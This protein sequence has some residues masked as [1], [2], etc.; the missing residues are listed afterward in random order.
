MTL[1]LQRPRQRILRRQ[2]KLEGIL[3]DGNGNVYA[4]KSRYYVRLA[5]QTDAT[6]NVT[7]GE[8]LPIRYAAASSVPPLEG[9][10]V[11]IAVDYDDELSI[12]RVKPDWFER[13]NIDSRTFNQAEP[14]DRFV[15]LMNIITK[16]TRPVGSA[17]SVDST[18]LTIRE[19]PFWVDDFLNWFIYAGT[20]RAA[21]KPDLASYIPAADTHRLIC[22]FFDTFQQDYFIAGSTAQALTTAIDSTDFDECFAQLEHNEYSPLLALKLANAQTAITINDMVEDLRQWLNAPKVYGN[23]NPLP[24]DKGMILRSTHQLIV[25]NYAFEGEAIIEGDLVIL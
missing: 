3:G 2:R 15:R 20:P 6:G 16:M 5:A 19:D 10:E 21:D 13:A 7:Y 23:P 22:V 4:S 18:L 17:S 9:V 11:L 1:A 12:E 25:Y 8:A 14:Y 24:A